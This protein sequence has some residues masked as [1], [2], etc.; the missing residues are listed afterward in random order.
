[1]SQY[2]LT[3]EQ[4]MLRGMVRRLAKEK[5]GPTAAERDEKAEFHW[6]IVKILRENELMGVDFPAEYGGGGAGTLA[7]IIVV[8]ELSKVD[9]SVGLTVAVQ[10]LGSLPIIL[11]G[12]EEQKRRYLPG[13]ASGD[14]LAAF[15]LTEPKAGSDVS[16][17]GCRA[18]KKGDE[19]ILNG[20]K[21]FITNGGV[22]DIHTIYAITKPE[23]KTHRQGSMFIVE[24]GFPGFRVGKK[25]DKLGIRSSDTVELI[26]EDCRVPAENL[27]MSEGNGF[28]VSMK[29]LDF[30]R[31]GIAAQ[32]LGIALG[33]FEYATQYAKE[34]EA[35]GKTISQFEGISFKL[36][37]MAIQTEAARQLIYKA[38]AVYQELPKDMSR[39]SPEQVRFS[40][41]A[42]TFCSDVAMWVTVE[43]VQVLG[44]YGYVKEYPVERMMRDAKIT[45]IYEGTNEIQRLITANSL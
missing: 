11:A 25:E 6:D 41:M 31:L 5:V 34:R 39:L 33:A 18:V 26:M 43:A 16:N 15:G 45:Q 35:F 42:K 12:N 32:G 9:A 44:G 27:L 8:E 20:S 19:Y 21:L 24:K 38:G 23:E 36:A 29:T 4:E 2:K 14:C 30:A 10:E 37:D 1:M 13:L 7:F 40:S 3:E 17:L 28:A 22:A